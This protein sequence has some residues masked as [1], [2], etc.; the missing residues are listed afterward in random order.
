MFVSQGAV[1]V[2]A[3]QGPGAVTL[4][5]GEGV[6]VRPGEPLVVRRW[7]QERVTQLFARFGR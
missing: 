5:P 1:A 7:P 2:S 6:D 4:G 3:R